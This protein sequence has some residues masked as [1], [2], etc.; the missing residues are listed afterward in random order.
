MSKAVAIQD[1]AFGD[2]SKGACVDLLSRRLPVDLIVRFGGSCQCAHNV[3]TPSGVH[4]TFSQFG[5]GML[6]NSTVRTHLSRFVL[7]D[8]LSMMNEAEELQHKTDDPWGRTT[9]DKNCVIITP[10]H[11]ILNRLRENARGENR[12]GSCGRGVGVAREMQLANP[13]NFLKAGDFEDWDQVWFK[14]QDQVETIGSMWYEECLARKEKPD[15]SLF[16][17]IDIEALIDTFKLWPARLVDEL[18]P[19]ELMVFEG[20]QGVMLDESHGTVPH[21]TWTDT[22]FNNADTLL[23]EVGVE[24]R[25]RIGCLRSYYTRHG[26]GPFPTE[27]E[28]MIDAFPEPHNGYG[29]YQ[30]AFRVGTFDMDL[31]KKALDIVGGVD[32]FSISHLDRLDDAMRFIRILEQETEIEVGITAF[33]PTADD[34]IFQSPSLLEWCDAYSSAVS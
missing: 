8:P 13:H 9:V 16:H 20:H 5:A 22:T 4:H 25:F 19:A 31:A 33:G 17:D 21:V 2:C 29:Q 12:H 23:D 24:E 34:R 26:H 14:L 3:V 7:V 15:L 18:E 32:C 6:A 27:V 1:L 28:G 30:G 10:F 11:K